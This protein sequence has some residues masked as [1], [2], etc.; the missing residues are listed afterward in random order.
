M[1]ENSHDPVQ[2]DDE[3]GDEAE[4]LEMSHSG[5]AR[6]TGGML[7]TLGLVLAA[8]YGPGWYLDKR[9]RAFE[10]CLSADPAERDA[11]PLSCLSKVESASWLAYVPW[12]RH[13]YSELHD[14]ARSDAHASQLRYFS[15]VEPSADKR[16][17]TLDRTAEL[18]D[19]IGPVDL[20]YSE[21]DIS[22]RPVPER[23]R[24]V[25][26]EASHAAGLLELA[27]PIRR[28]PLPPCA[29]SREV[30]RRYRPAR[31]AGRSRPR[32]VHRRRP[33]RMRPV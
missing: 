3:L 29:P 8:W 31:L 28:T 1:A 25:R 15:T 23:H 33:C 6:W 19:R 16:A 14:S 12:T 21:P 13:D 27:R 22:S 5:F 18:S 4:G 24:R 7:V 10:A 20:A 9:D 2:P 17:E 30:H 32:G 26:R 11:P